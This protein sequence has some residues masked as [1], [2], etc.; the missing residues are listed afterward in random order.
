[1]CFRCESDLGYK[2]MNGVLVVLS[3]KI[4]NDVVLPTSDV[5]IHHYKR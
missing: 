2:M 4:V 5:P 1:M 3:G